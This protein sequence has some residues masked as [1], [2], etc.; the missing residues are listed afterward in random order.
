M[1][2]LIQNIAG[3]AQVRENAPEP[4]KGADL[5]ELPVLQ[6]AYLYL[7]DG[8]VADFGRMSQCPNPEAEVIDASGRW[9]FPS[10]VD[11]HSHLVFAA[12]RE[13]EFVM[14]L[15]G[16]SYEEIAAEGGGI[17]NSAKR[18]QQTSEASLL[19][20]ALQRLDEVIR[21]GTGV[22]EIKSGY[23][24]SYEAELKMLRVIRQLKKESPIP[25]KA[26][27]LGAHAIPMEYRNNREAYISEVKDRMLPAVAEEGLAEYMDV[28]C[29]RGF[30]SQEETEMLLAAGREYGLKPKVHANELGYTGGVQ[31]G[32]NQNAVSVD[33]LECTGEDELEA[34]KA[35]STIPV[36][37]PSTA[38]FLDIDPPPARQMADAGLPIALSTDYNPGS[39]PSG[40]MPFTAAL[41]SVKLKLLPEE[42]LNA[43]TVNAAH[44]IEMGQDY[45]HIRKGAAANVFITDPIP[46]YTFLPYSFG[47]EH[48]A[49]VLVNGE[50]YQGLT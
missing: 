31:A 8:K 45:G 24:L 10:Y 7:S 49:E 19:E 9:V 25:I 40:S 38:F 36:I 16:K 43:A 17:L 18:L 37:L 48:I 6:D 32:V 42:S 34:L 41:G 5:K 26:T 50:R 12:S 3:L 21:K 22:L 13:N 46:S 28:F 35:S 27:F 33:H 15:K 29:E 11:A 23:G 2:I 1:A 44:A 14:R 20:S 4:L 30:F 47:N 39:C